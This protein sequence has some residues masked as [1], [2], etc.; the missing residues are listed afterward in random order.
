MVFIVREHTRP[1]YLEG[2]RGSVPDAASPE[3]TGGL[4]F[5]RTLRTFGILYHVC[6][7]SGN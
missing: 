6:E 1:L 2:N 4:T 5:H 3:G 7:L